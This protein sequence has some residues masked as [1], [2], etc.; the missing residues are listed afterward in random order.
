MNTVRTWINRLRRDW[1]ERWEWYRQQQRVP[2]P[3]NWWDVYNT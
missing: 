3:H 2:R 1:R